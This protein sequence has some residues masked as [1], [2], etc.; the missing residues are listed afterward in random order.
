MVGSGI[1]T[2]LQSVRNNLDRSAI[3]T[4]TLIENACHNL[5]VLFKFKAKFIFTFIITTL[6]IKYFI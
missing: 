6:Y 3:L 1:W 4:T 5:I 2:K